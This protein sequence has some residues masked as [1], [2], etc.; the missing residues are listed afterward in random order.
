MT[1]A[2]LRVT[3]GRILRAAGAVTLAGAVVMTPGGR[4]GADTMGPQYTGWWS[5][6]QQLPL[7]VPAPTVPDG[8]MLVQQGA[9]GPTAYGA[10]HYSGVPAGTGTILLDVSTGSTASLGTIAACTTTQPWKATKGPGSWS[11][12]PSYTTDCTP[13]I[14]ATDGSAVAFSV[15]VPAGNAGVLDLAIVPTATSLPFSVTFDKPSAKSLNINPVAPPPPPVAEAAAPAP[16]A[17]AASP[18]DTSA[19][20]V[21]PAPVSDSFA[22]AP[23]PATPAAPSETVPTQTVQLAAA[24]PAGGSTSDHRGQRIAAVAG[25]L[26][27]VGGWWLVGARPTRAPQLLG[28]FAEGG[29]GVLGPER[30]VTMGGIGRFARPR[31]S[32]PRRLM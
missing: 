22:S 32:R 9:N 10:V 13:G 2:Q 19:V 27:L 31:Q 26:A 20:V 5:A 8:G 14:A 7:A 21:P 11:S 25:L 6:T 29:A 23:V 1:R 3:G 17:T 12:R 18:A 16:D 15:S 30:P 4:A 28:A 24:P